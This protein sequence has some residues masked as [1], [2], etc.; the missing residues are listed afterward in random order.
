[1]HTSCPVAILVA[2]MQ[3]AA[4]VPLH[5]QPSS[6]LDRVGRGRTPNH[7]KVVNGAEAP[8]DKYPWVVGLDA[9][10]KGDASIYSCGGSLIAPGYVLTAAHCFYPTRSGWSGTAYFGAHESCFYGGCDAQQRSIAKVFLHPNYNDRTSANDI[11]ILQLDKDVSN[12]EPVPIKK[13]G[14]TK[15]DTFGNGIHKAATVLGWGVSNAAAE[16]M[17]EV[18]QQ[19]ELTL[20]SRNDC[21]TNNMYK[22]AKKDIKYGMMCANNLLNLTDACQGDSGGPLFVA[23]LGEQVGLVS[24]GEGCGRKKY[25]GVYTDVGRHYKWIDGIIGFDTNS[26]PTLQPIATA[27]PPTPSPTPSP[28]PTPPQPTPTPPQ[29]TP[30]P[31]ICLDKWSYDTTAGYKTFVGCADADDDGDAW[32]YTT[33]ACAGSNPSSVFDGWQWASCAVEAAAAPGTMC[34]SLSKSACKDETAACTW[35][36]GGCK[37]LPDPTSCASIANS[38]KTCTRTLTVSDCDWVSKKCVDALICDPSTNVCCA[39]NK[40]KCKIDSSCEWYN[41]RKQCMP[42]A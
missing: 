36:N 37:D 20:L 19:G 6:Q 31:C 18:L 25:P 14:Y 23:S 2:L 24:W 38:W 40:N 3:T 7:Q 13:K 12:I 30:T 35:K 21:G 17:S 10:I 9:R 28:T 16:T 34:K 32:C 4:S 26:K 29:P 27:A 11:A 8:E 39:K 33:D 5:Q 42:A 22:H 15:L 1:M 41:S